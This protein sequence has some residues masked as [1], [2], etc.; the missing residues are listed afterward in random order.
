MQLTSYYSG[1]AAIYEL[2]ERLKHS[3]RDKFDLRRFH[4]QFL[5]YGNAPVK[6]IAA[7]MEAPAEPGP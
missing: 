2:R 3:Q 4:D 6:M 1:Y 7:L 5:S